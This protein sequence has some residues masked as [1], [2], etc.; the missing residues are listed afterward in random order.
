MALT[1]TEKRRLRSLGHALPVALTVGKGGASEGVAA[2]LREL[3][4]RDELLK[5]RLP[6]GPPDE[7][8]ALAAELASAAGA[9]VAGSVGRTVLLY[10]K[11]P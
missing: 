1:G 8:A 7:R 10:K 5:V 4:T 2:Q 11:M 9:A 3:F 6:A